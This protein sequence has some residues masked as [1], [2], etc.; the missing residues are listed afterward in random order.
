M[1]K[2]YKGKNCAYC[3]AEKSETADHVFPRELFL[4][5]NRDGIPKVPACINCNNDKSKLEHYLATVLP[6]GGRH[7][8]AAETL[9][10]QVT[11]RLHRNKP[12]HQNLIDGVVPAWSPE[13]DGFEQSSGLPLEWPKLEKWM[14]YVVRGLN[15]H[16][17]DHHLTPDIE[18]KTYSLS[19]KNENY[20]MDL[21]A[22][23]RSIK[24]GNRTVEYVGFQTHENKNC[25]I[26]MM[27]L[28]GGIAVFSDEDPEATVGQ[29]I[30]VITLP[31]K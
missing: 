6:F 3:K 20:L 7:S 21:V 4:K 5:N 23:N 24:V 30:G 12:L 22:E 8:D 16:H 18:I 14:S 19:Y 25:T 2:Q 13:D 9:L 31:S 17:W 10:N 11:K 1:S 28:F 26:W 29:S 15:I 27:R